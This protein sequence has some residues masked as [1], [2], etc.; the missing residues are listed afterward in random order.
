M[1]NARTMNAATIP[2]TV[3]STTQPSVTPHA[4]CRYNPAMSELPKDLA[5]AREALKTAATSISAVSHRLIR[6]GELDQIEFHNLVIALKHIG[7]ADYLVS[8]HERGGTYNV[9]DLTSVPID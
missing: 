6:D 3:H 1:T 5:D 2:H 4:P 7:A 8:R 9:K